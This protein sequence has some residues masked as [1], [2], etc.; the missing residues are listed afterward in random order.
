MNVL[1]VQSTQAPTLTPLRGLRRTDRAATARQLAP[2]MMS[3][4][5]ED[6]GLTERG[7]MGIMSEQLE[8]TETGEHHYEARRDERK[9][10]AS[11]EPHEDW[12]VVL[13]IGLTEDASPEDASAAVARC[14]APTLEDAKQIAQ[15]WE[16]ERELR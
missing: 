3:A 8:W 2:A 7:L 1:V 12:C 6:D 11:R 9:Y 15:Q 10:V 14:S 13:F 4:A 5:D 16:L